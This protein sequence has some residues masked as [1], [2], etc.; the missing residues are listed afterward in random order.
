MKRESFSI[1]F[2]LSA[3]GWFL[4]LLTAVVCPVQV[5]AQ[6]AKDEVKEF[7]VKGVKFRMVKVDGGAFRMTDKYI[8][9]VSTYYIGETEV[10]QELWKAIM[11]NNPSKVENPLHPVGN[12]SWNACQEFIKQLNQLTGMNFRLPTEAEWTYAAIGGSRSQGFAY[13]GS[14]TLNDVAWWARNEEAYINFVAK[15]DGKKRIAGKITLSEPQVVATRKPNELGLYDMT[16][17]V[18]E[19]CLDW[20]RDTLPRGRMTDP[21]GP[22]KGKM[23]TF[24]G[25]S[26]NSD[27]EESQIAFRDSGM[28]SFKYEDVGFRLVLVP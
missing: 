10:T 12:V 24:R 4:L 15:K 17:N 11:G 13:S 23:K 20:H 9:A 19:W 7:D 27:E 26:W 6:S 21:T 14:N 28:P 5:A 3:A 25:G 1:S 18:W 2:L 8:V 22:E 16:G